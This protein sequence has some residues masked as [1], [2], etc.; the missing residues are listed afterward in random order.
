MK[1]ATVEDLVSPEFMLTR[2]LSIHNGI[3]EHIRIMPVESFDLYSFTT[4][5]G[6]KEL[7]WIDLQAERIFMSA[8]NKR[9]GTDRVRIIGEESLKDTIDLKTETRICLLVDM[10]D[11]TDLLQRKFGNWCSAVVVFDPQVPSILASFVAVPG[12][13]AAQPGTLYYASAKGAFKVPLRRQKTL[14]PRELQCYRPD[15][16][17]YDASVCMYAQKNHAFESLIGLHRRKKF[18]SWVRQNGAVNRRRQE[19]NEDELQF[20]FY[21]LA[22]N[23]MMVR[24]CDDTVDVV[25]DLKGQSPHD[26]V[27]G[28]YIA[29]RA[30]AVMGT[31]E[32]SHLTEM[33]LAKS[34]L[35]PADSPLKYILASNE[36]MFSQLSGLLTE[37]PRGP[38]AGTL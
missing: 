26:V 4:G 17:L 38:Q 9:I 18:L 14:T 30:G 28:A 7:T 3:N 35:R 29:L 16:M 23:P 1:Y 12:L 21:D 33:H 11:G 22:G 24:M 10:I 6:R 32:G 20:R 37:K 19:K 15:K 5:S 25:F 36:Q 13:S 2:I 8:V 34:L 27:P 31:I